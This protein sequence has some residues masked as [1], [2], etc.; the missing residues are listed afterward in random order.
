MLIFSYIYVKSHQSIK[1]TNSTHRYILPAYS[2]IITM[3]E[4]F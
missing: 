1:K 3:V 4:N 2:M